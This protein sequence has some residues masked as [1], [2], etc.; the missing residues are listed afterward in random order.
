MFENPFLVE[1]FLNFWRKSG[2]QVIFFNE[3]LNDGSLSPATKILVSSSHDPVIHNIFSVY[4]FLVLFKIPRCPYHSFQSSQFIVLKISH[5]SMSFRLDLVMRL[6][7]CLFFFVFK[8][9][10]LYTSSNNNPVIRIFHCFFIIF[11]IFLFCVLS[12][13]DPSFS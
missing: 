10:L 12:N 5:F 4:L 9:F 6:F 1:R 13:H 8:I 11:K 7:H 3:Y 2:K